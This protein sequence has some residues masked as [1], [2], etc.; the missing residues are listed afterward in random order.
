MLKYIGKFKIIHSA[1]QDRKTDPEY[2]ELF[3]EI[4][5][6]MVINFDT[7]SFEDI[8]DLYKQMKALNDMLPEIDDV[9]N[10]MFDGSSFSVPE[11]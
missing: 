3:L 9:E 8:E 11:S 2:Q 4:E 5:Q 6:Y 10:M 1:L 7:T